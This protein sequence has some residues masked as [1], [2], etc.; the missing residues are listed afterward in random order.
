MVGDGWYNCAVLNDSIVASIDIKKGDEIVVGNFYFKDSAEGLPLGII[1]QYKRWEG[2]WVA[3]G[4][5]AD[6]CVYVIYIL[7]KV[8]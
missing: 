2:G 8:L 6:S 1:H 3:G 4:W 5:V 7:E